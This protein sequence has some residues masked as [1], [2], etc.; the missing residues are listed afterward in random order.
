MLGA[1]RLTDPDLTLATT[2]GWRKP[3]QRGVAQLVEQ[4]SPKPQVAGSNPV[5]PASGRLAGPPVTE[6]APEP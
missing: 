1:R 5:A 4:R 3:A 6:Q 2:C